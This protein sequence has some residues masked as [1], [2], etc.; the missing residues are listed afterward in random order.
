MLYFLGCHLIDLIFR[1]Q[2]IPEEIIPLSVSTEKGGTSS[3]D[4]GAAVFRY[5]HGISYAKVSATEVN[6]HIRRQLVVSGE[7][8]T[9]EIKPLEAY[10]G[11]IPSWNLHSTYKFSRAEDAKT[12]ADCGKVTEIPPFDRYIQM[13]TDFA[14][15]VNGDIENPYSYEYEYALHRVILAA[16]G[17]DIDYKG[18]FTL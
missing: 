13:L 18:D 6:G 2:G 3:L 7:K 17:F 16:C 11:N 1:L 10:I 4:F 14:R 5:K 15:Y 12:W 8:A 9:M